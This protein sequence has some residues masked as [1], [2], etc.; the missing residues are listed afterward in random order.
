MSNLI[1]KRINADSINFD[2]DTHLYLKSN[3]EKSNANLIFDTGADGLYLDSVFIAKNK[4]TFTK[5]G[6]AKLGGTGGKEQKVDIIRDSLCYKLNN[7]SL[8]SVMTP[9]LQLRPIVGRKVDGIVG[10]SEFKDKTIFINYINQKL[11]VFKSS[12]EEILKDYK[13]IAVIE[14]KNRYFI[15]AT[16]N[17]KKDLLINGEFLIDLGSGGIIDIT[18]KVSLQNALNDKIKNKIT[19]NSINNGVGGDGS[20]TYFMSESVSV[21]D[22]TFKNENLSYSNNV[23]G[24]LSD[25]DYLGLIGNG[26]FQRFDLIIDFKSKYLYLKP[27]INFHKKPAFNNL[28]FSCVDRT[29]I[30]KGFIVSALF[31]NS[32]V[33]K[34]GLKLGDIITH[35]NDKNVEDI[36]DYTF[37]KKTKNKQKIKIRFKRDNIVQEI[38]FTTNNLFSYAYD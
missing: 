23:S 9:I 12:N 38:Y 37:F 27:N 8:K 7:I 2:Y 25:R 34:K 20:D 31:K 32:E 21:N 30:E 35:I 6:Y 16:V 5:L 18:N 11:Y 29:D 22:F 24:A 26:F 1:T 28:G 13:K 19:S 17:I 10:N 4:M 15:N 3:I 33:E 36:D 14:R